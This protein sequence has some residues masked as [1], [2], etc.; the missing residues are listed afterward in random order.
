M[1]NKW[2]MDF[3]VPLVWLLPSAVWSTTIYFTILLFL[4]V[5]YVLTH[6]HN[7]SLRGFK[8]QCWL[9]HSKL[10]LWQ[11][12]TLFGDFHFNSKYWS[13][14]QSQ[15][16]SICLATARIIMEFIYLAVHWQT[17][18]CCLKVT[19]LSGE[20]RCHRTD[21]IVVNKISFFIS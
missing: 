12:V 15:Y 18:Q 4:V 1:N 9:W 2:R 17:C 19:V 6:T 7:T 3:T 5:V 21:R 16:I 20:A 13:M 11:N 14:H 8:I 10:K